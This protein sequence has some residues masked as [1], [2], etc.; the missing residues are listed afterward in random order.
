M[1]DRQPQAFVLSLRRDA[2]TPGF[3]PS[4]GHGSVR[5]STLCE[6]RF[7]V[8]DAYSGELETKVKDA[9]RSITTALAR[10]S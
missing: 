7:V 5:E 8:E 6:I 1:A 4:G 3:A 2:S 10:N 9:A